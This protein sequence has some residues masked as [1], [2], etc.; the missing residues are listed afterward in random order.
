MDEREPLK[1]KLVALTKLLSYH[2]MRIFKIE[3]KIKAI[4]LKLRNME[5]EERGQ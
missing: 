1:E 4:N 5:M 2:R 3:S